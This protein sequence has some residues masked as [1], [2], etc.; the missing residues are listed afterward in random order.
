MRIQYLQQLNVSGT[1][2]QNRSLNEER[3]SVIGSVA[4]LV[5]QNNRELSTLKANLQQVNENCRTEPSGAIGGT[6]FKCREKSWV[7]HRSSGDGHRSQRTSQASEITGNGVGFIK[8]SLPVTVAV[9]S[10]PAGEF[11]YIERSLTEPMRSPG[12]HQSHLTLPSHGAT[13]ATKCGSRQ[14]SAEPAERH[15]RHRQHQTA[16]QTGDHSGE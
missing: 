13:R 14:P 1:N 4:G 7:V 6:I 2:W 12:Q 11:G 16:L 10:F 15:G 5:N 9:D 3:E 8:L